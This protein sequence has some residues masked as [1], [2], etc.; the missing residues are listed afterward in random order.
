MIGVRIVLLLGIVVVL[1]P[2]LAYF[3]TRNVY[4]YRFAMKSGKV[5]VAL[6]AAIALVYLAERLILVL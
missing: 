2:L 3:I 4:F 1:A 5:V 6:L